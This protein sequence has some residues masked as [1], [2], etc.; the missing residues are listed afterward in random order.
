MFRLPSLALVLCLAAGCAGYR[1]G[2]T[3]GDTAGARS[4][5]V[6]FF[7]N[8][9]LEPR[10]SAPVN[11]ALRKAIQQDG[12]YRLNTREDGD[13]VVNGE[14]T[15]FDR[16]GVSFQPTDVITVRDYE[17]SLTARVIV[18]ERSTGRVV[19]DRD[20]RGKT[21]V[22]VGA[23]LGSAERQALPLIAE[24]LARNTTSLLVDGAW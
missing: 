12:T 14:I 1:L 15:R 16:S 20:V 10:L 17:L 3:N 24:D 22:R 5:Q 6:N 18:T 11:Q 13:L 2:P 9:T 21:L 23:D 7:Q 8:K 4:I 19:L